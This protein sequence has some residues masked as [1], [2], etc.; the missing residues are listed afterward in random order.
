MAPKVD[1]QSKIFT[2]REIE[3]LIASGR[4]IVI[5]D[6]KV[7]KVDAWLPYH[8]GG[9]KAIRHMIGRDATDEVQRYVLMCCR[10]IIF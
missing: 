9:D 3:T 8:P 6:K 10:Q 1:R 5:V 2:R 4:S 7:L